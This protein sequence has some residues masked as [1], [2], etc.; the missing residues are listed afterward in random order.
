MYGESNS[1]MLSTIN[2]GLNVAQ[3]SRQEFSGIGHPFNP[4]TY[5]AANLLA[6]Y[7]GDSLSTDP[8]N[9]WSDQ[10]VNGYDLTLFNAPAIVNLGLN[11]HD[12]L[13]FNGINQCGRVVI[14]TLGQPLT[15]YVA[16]KQITW[17]FAN[18]ILNSGNGITQFAMS[19]ANVS[20][21]TTVYAGNILISNPNV[22]LNT[23][24]IITGVWNG[25]NSEIRTNNNAA[26]IGNAN[27]QNG[28]LTFD[29]ATRA[30]LGGYGNIETAYIILRSAADNTATQNI[31][32]NFLKNRFAL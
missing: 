22:V 32:I 5:D 31:F 3:K 6:L 4:L 8:A 23:F 12:T 19:Q 18:I 28:N 1:R 16:V 26:V 11:G 7:D 2:K 9:T 21:E 27:L 10:S 17:T 29:V 25:A 24:D 13:K 15:A 14:A 30:G 20:P